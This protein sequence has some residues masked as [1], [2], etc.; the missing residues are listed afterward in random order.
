[1]TEYLQTLTDLELE[2]AERNLYV[3]DIV[4][5][6]LDILSSIRIEKEYREQIVEGNKTIKK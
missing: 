2:Q 6:A 3:D 4:G 1:M 5:D